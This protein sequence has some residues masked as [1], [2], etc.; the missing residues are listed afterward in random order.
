MTKSLGKRAFSD[1]L[2]GWTV[3]TVYER[4]REA[5]L[6]AATPGYMADGFGICAPDLFEGIVG[7]N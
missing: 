3:K 4:K 5:F 6:T 1:S 7:F 2:L